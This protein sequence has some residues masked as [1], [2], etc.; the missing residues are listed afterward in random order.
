M[1]SNVTEPKQVNSISLSVL[2]PI[3]FPKSND[4][5]KQSCNRKH[6]CAGPTVSNRVP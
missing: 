3:C 4:T 2:E 6:V 5:L 1:T